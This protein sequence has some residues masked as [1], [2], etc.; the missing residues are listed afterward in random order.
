MAGIQ[1]QR[2]NGCFDNPGGSHQTAEFI[3]VQGKMQNMVCSF[4]VHFGRQAQADLANSVMLRWAG[5][6]EEGVLI[7]QD[8]FNNAHNARC[9]S[10]TG[11][12]LE[13][14]DVITC[15]PRLARN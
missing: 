2:R 12:S 10:V 11:C 8:G 5:N 7:P 15:G 1:V 4:A 3:L 13:P 6:R 14:H 9:H